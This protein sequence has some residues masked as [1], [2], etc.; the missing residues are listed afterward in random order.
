MKTRKGN[1]GMYSTK[2]P[3]S[4]GLQELC[5]MVILLPPTILS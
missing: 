3:S 1:G 5:Y 2:D 4:M